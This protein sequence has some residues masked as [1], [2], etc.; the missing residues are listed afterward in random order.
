MSPNVLPDLLQY[1]FL[2]TVLVIVMASLVSRS[3]KRRV[4][5]L[6]PGDLERAVRRS[7]RRFDFSVLLPLAHLTHGF[8]SGRSF[9]SISSW[10]RCWSHRLPEALPQSR[11]SRFTFIGDGR[12]FLWCGRH[13]ASRR[14]VWK[15]RTQTTWFWTPRGQAIVSQ[16]WLFQC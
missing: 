5:G 16:F 13:D 1:P 12:S 9:W 11:P 6:L 15:R 3:R 4:Q 2:T 14:L 8:H 7:G 10:A